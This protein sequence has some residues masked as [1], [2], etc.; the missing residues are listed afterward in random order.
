MS[1]ADRRKKREIEREEAERRRAERPIVY[2][3]AH[4]RVRNTRGAAKDHTCEF[5]GAQAQD[6]S[7]KADAKGMIVTIRASGTEER[8]SG[9]PMDYRPLCRP[10]HANYDRLARFLG[11]KFEKGCS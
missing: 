5:C 1:R 7:L 9:D 11:P 6:W 8:Y 3:T 2:N 10:C 4:Q